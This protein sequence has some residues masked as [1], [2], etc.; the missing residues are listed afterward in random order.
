MQTRLEEETAGRTTRTTGNKNMPRTRW[1]PAAGS[2]NRDTERG[3]IHGETTM[4]NTTNA[5]RTP[6]DEGHMPTRDRYAGK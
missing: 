6:A 4:Q 2:R 5:R 1:T 3:Q